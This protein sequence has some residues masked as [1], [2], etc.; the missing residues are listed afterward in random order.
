LGQIR[1]VLASDAAFILEF[2]NKLNLKAILRYWF[3][4]QSW[5]PFTPDP[6][7]FA[8]LNFD[9]HPKM[10]RGWLEDLGFRIEK[11]LA[12]SHF[13]AGFL[14]RALPVGA[15]VFFDSLFQWTG[16]LWQLTPS[17]FLRARVGHREQSLSEVPANAVA[18]FKCPA[19][20]NTPLIEQESD[21][22]CPGCKRT[23]G[24]RDG[25]FDFRKPLS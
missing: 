20:G 22:K 7:E 6:V 16:T 11:T 1:N 10:V 3:G 17:V 14:K 12:V 9:F 24:V 19:C 23:W 4:R 8:E 5:S 2:A 25:I 13:R 18:F 21:L 15:L